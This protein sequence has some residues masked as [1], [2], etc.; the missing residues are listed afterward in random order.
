MTNEELV[1]RY[2][3]ALEKI[4]QVP[5]ESAEGYE[6]EFYAIAREALGISEPI[7]DCTEHILDDLESEN[8]GC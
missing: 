2:K 5:E 7:C 1:N 8:S 6:G 4:L 3:T